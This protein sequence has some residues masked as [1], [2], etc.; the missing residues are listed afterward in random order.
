MT[1]LICLLIAPLLSAATLTKDINRIAESVDATVG[2][3]A[4]DLDSGRSV[5]IRGN[6]PF[7]MASVFKFPLAVEVLRCVD[8]GS[9]RLDQKFTILPAEFSLGHSPIATARRESRSHSCCAN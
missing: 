5:V 8:S 1:T 2:V 6:E 7:P 9:L 3:A 4:V